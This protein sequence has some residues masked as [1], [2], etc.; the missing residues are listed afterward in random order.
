LRWEQVDLDHARV[1]VFL[2]DDRLEHH[3]ARLDAER[4]PLG[5]IERAEVVCGV[6]VRVIGHG[7]RRAGVRWDGRWRAAGAASNVGGR[8]L[9]MLDRVKSLCA[10]LGVLSLY[11]MANPLE[12]VFGWLK[13]P[14]PARAQPSARLR[15]TLRRAR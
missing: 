5:E 3:A 9:A 1:H 15:E 12:G 14:D 4:E 6:A 2:G 10:S 7:A 13:C 11:V 8:A